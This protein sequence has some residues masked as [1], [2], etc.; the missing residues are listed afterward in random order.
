MIIQWP[1]KFWHT[2]EDTLDKVDPHMLAVLGGL[3]T[4][5]AYF[6]ANA[7]QREVT[8]LG[9]EMLARFRARLAHSVQGALTDVLATKEGEDLAQE[10]ALLER[11]VEFAADRQREATRSLLRLAPQEEGL[12]ANLSREVD[13]AAH[14]EL[15]RAREVLLWHAE[16]LGLDEIPPLPAREPDEWERQGQAMVPSRV[17][18]GPASPHLHR[19]KLTVQEKEELHAWQKEH[20]RLYRVL[21]VV[22]N[23]WVDGKRTVADIADL[24]ELETGQRNVELLVKHFNLMGRVGLVN[25]QTNHSPD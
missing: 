18:R 20:H 15:G 4:T 13:Q 17:F 21:G 8:W 11:M 12:I 10:G 24:V 3:A 9:R 6:V 19:H 7:G 23:Y 1:D 14:T 16:Y 22:A 5:Y 25:L 2:S